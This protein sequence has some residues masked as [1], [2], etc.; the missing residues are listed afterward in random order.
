MDTVELMREPQAVIS[1][2]GYLF[3]RLPDSRYVDDFDNTD[4]AYDSLAQITETCDILAPSKTATCLAGYFGWTQEELEHSL[5]T[6]NFVYG[7]ENTVPLKNG[8]EIRWP[9]SPQSCT[10]VRVVQAGFELAYWTCDDEHHWFEDVM[11]S[12]LSCC[13]GQNIPAS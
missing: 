11:G 13:S 9:A 8:R 5:K 4:L 6:L 1:E 10:Y 7:K 3:F 12:F 2:D